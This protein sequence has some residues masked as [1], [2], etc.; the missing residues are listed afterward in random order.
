MGKYKNQTKVFYWILTAVEILGRYAFAVPAYR[1]GTKNMTK[2]VRL[3]LKKLNPS[4][5]TQFDDN[6]ENHCSLKTQEM[7]ESH[8][9]QVFRR[10]DKFRKNDVPP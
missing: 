10:Q 5:T 4:L 1:N 8:S 9:F 6:K 7:G 3:L 2:T